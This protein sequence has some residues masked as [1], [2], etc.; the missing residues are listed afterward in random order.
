MMRV[1]VIVRLLQ[2]QRALVRHGLDEYVRETHLFRPFRFLMLLSPWVCFQRSRGVTR[3]ER[4]RM[5]LEDLGPIF[6]KFGQALSTRRDLLPLDIADELAKLQ[7]RVPPFPNAVAAATIEA[8][9]GGPIDSFFNDFEAEPMAAAS[10]AQVHAARLKDGSDVIVKVLRPG[11]HEI[12]RRD[13]DVLHALARSRQRGPTEAQFRGIFA[14]VRAGRALGP[15]P[16]QRHGHGTDPRHHHQ[17][18]R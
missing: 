2:I 18:D 8:A 6:V 14:A 11:M 13:I 1:R 4:L 10:I 17:P 16:Q 9:L 5:A 15:V 12:I 3:G 7:D